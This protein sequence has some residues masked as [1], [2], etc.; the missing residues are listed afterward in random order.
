M[1]RLN[2]TVF[3]EGGRVYLTVYSFIVHRPFVTVERY[4]FELNRGGWR[5]TANF[6]TADCGTRGIGEEIDNDIA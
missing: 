2:V 3:S 5:V 6:V 4:Q 1:S